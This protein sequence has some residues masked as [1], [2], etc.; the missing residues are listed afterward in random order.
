MN[1]LE[2]WRTKKIKEIKSWFLENINNI[3]ILL[4]KLTKKKEKRHKLTKSEMQEGTWVP[5]LQN[6]KN[7]K[8]LYANRLDN[9]N[10]MGKFLERK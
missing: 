5:T 3:D 10:E 9:V 6:L 4:A 7:Y 1:E 2:N 8:Q